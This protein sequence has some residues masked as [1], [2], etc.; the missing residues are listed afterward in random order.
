[1]GLILEQGLMIQ[2]KA[3]SLTKAPFQYRARNR[4]RGGF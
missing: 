1:M 3:L 4:K 2:R